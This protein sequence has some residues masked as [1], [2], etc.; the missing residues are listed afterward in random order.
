MTQE[1]K[2]I[3]ILGSGCAKCK[4]LEQH[5][6]KAVKELSIDA[7]IIKVTDIDEITEK[8]VFFTPALV[9]NDELKVTGKVASIEEIKKLL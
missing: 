4:K 2:K 8:G 7:E 6:K 5:V 9:I 3:E 1:K